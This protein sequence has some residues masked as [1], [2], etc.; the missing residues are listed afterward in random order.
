M[1]TR[2]SKLAGWWGVLLPIALLALVFQTGGTIAAAQAGAFPAFISMPGVSPRGVAVDKVGNVYVSVGEVRSTLEYIQVRK[3]TPAGEPLFSVEIG[4]GTIGGL[5]VTA[6]GDLYI[7]IA[8]GSARG[9]YRMDREGQ[10]GFLPPLRENTVAAIR[11]HLVASAARQIHLTRL[12]L[13]RPHAYVSGPSVLLAVLSPSLT[14]YA[15]RRNFQDLPVRQ[16]RAKERSF[17]C[18]GSV[19]RPSAVAARLSCLLR[20]RPLSLEVAHYSW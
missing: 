11:R 2:R 3:F 4:Q 9:V 7:A 19:A 20:I 17:Q 1:R 5:M 16:P 12:F 10:I 14:G 18:A 15:L 8:A 6:N 13:L